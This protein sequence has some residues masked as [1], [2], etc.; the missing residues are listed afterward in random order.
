MWTQ[1][2]ELRAQ[3]LCCT[4]PHSTEAMFGH[5]LFPFC[6]LVWF[7]L[8]WHLV[9]FEQHDDKMTGSP[10]WCPK[11]Q[12]RGWQLWVLQILWGR[13]QCLLLE[14]RTNIWDIEISSCDI[15]FGVKGPSRH[16]IPESNR[17]LMERYEN[18]RM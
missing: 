8:G 11:N 10:L 6:F 1:R 14:V 2:Q 9:N 7:P 4:V 18:Q 5:V 12:R 16:V 17:I 15:K 13:K 3:S